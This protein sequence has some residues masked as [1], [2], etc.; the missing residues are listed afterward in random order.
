MI[1]EL[2]REFSCVEWHSSSWMTPSLIWAP[3]RLVTF[4][5]IHPKMLTREQAL[6]HTL[7]CRQILFLAWLSA[8]CTFYSTGE[9]ESHR[10]RNTSTSCPY[11]LTWKA[12]WVFDLFLSTAEEMVLQLLEP[13]PT[14]ALRITFYPSPQRTYSIKCILLSSPGSSTSVRLTQLNR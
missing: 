2:R 5:Q 13:N 9:T 3:A 11:L 1:T 14:C 6:L 4:H 10:V 8:N 7:L 12:V